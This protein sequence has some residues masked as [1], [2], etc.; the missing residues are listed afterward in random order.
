VTPVKEEKTPVKKNQLT[1]KLQK[2]TEGQLANVEKMLAQMAIEEQALSKRK[3]LL[4][5]TRE[6]LE[7]QL[8]GDASSEEKD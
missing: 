2:S 3:A 4:L 5:E 8:A 1:P 6:E 7:K